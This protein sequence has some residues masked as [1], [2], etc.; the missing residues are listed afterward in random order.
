MCLQSNKLPSFTEVFCV[1]H[2][3]RTCS[4]IAECG[5]FIREI[6]S[7]HVHSSAQTDELDELFRTENYERV[8]LKKINPVDWLI[9]DTLLV[10][11]C[12]YDGNFF[13]GLWF[14]RRVMDWH[15]KFFCTVCWMLVCRSSGD[16][17]LFLNLLEQHLS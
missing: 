10:V 16:Y 1:R 15:K 7:H 12:M 2:F 14:Y 11:S 5:C 8:L 9:R 13:F 4:R 17:Y 6:T 3:S